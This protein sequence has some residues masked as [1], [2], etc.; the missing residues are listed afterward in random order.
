MM[1]DAAQEA[2]LQKAL[3]HPTMAGQIRAV[4][5]NPDRPVLGR[6]VGPGEP[7]SVQVP[8]AGGPGLSDKAYTVIEEF[9]VAVAELLGPEVARRPLERTYKLA[10]S[11]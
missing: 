3:T 11:G 2:V 5:F 10:G 9:A 1:F 4:L 6:P 7:P 8:T